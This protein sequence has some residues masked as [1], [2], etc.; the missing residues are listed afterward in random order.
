M[1]LLG[2]III[3]LFTFCPCFCL[4]SL[5]H[6]NFD[7]QTSSNCLLKKTLDAPTLIHATGSLQDEIPTQTLT[8]NTSILTYAFVKTPR[9]GAFDHTYSAL[10]KKGENSM[11]CLDF[12]YY[13]TD[14]SHNAKIGVELDIGSTRQPIIELIATPNSKWQHCQHSYSRPSSSTYHV[15]AT[16]TKNV[17][18]EYVLDATSSGTSNTNNPT[19]DTIITTTDISSITTDTSSITTDTSSI[20]TDTSSITTDTSS[21]TT[22]TSSITTDTSSIT[23]DTSSIT[24]DTSSITTDTSSITTDTSSIT[25]DT[26]SITT[27]T[28]SITTD[29][30]SDAIDTSATTIDKSIT[31]TG[32]SGITTD[33]SITTSDQN[34]ATTNM[35][36][37]TTD[38]GDTASYYSS[39]ATGTISTIMSTPDII[40]DSTAS[41]SATSVTW[42]ITGTTMNATITI[43]VTIR[44]PTPLLLCDFT[45][46]ACFSVGNESVEVTDGRNYALIHFELGGNTSKK[47]TA[48]AKPRTQSDNGI[49]KQCLRYYYYMTYY[50]DTLYREIQVYI[51]NS[52]GAE[53]KRIDTVPHQNMS[54]NGWQRRRVDFDWTNNTYKLSFNFRIDSGNETNNKSYSPIYFALDD[55]DLYDGD[56]ATGPN[57]ALILGL[58]LGLGI[59]AV[60]GA[61][62]GSVYYFGKKKHIS[63]SLPT[64]S[65]TYRDILRGYSYDDDDDNNKDFKT[66]YF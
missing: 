43:T 30:S 27:D 6:C 18:E 8:D 35:S 25:T 4:T 34:I 9:V 14:S 47:V 41:S 32:I 24:T 10:V 44:P 46:D 31:T 56:C 55:I 29:T 1:Q 61:I 60:A 66:F 5:Y 16:N 51:E 19:M 28:S 50:D 22:D 39:I 23:T 38:I 57:L 54:A 59:P 63:K 20:T 33:T 52:R 53:E 62:G 42:D 49:S 45:N 26:S 48:D 21:I 12:Y 7:T 2:G 15:T 58:S 11:Q 40:T 13:I 17:P 37:I 3:L 65:D 64:A 36:S